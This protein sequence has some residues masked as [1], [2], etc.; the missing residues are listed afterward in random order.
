MGRLKT[1]LLMLAGCI[2]GLC[3]ANE[4]GAPAPT[5]AQEKP[6]SFRLDVMPVFFR[7][8]CNS[9]G[10]HG[11]ARGKDGFRL[12]LFG[13]DPA[14]DY[15]RLTQQMAG[16]RINLSVPEESLLLLKVTGKVPHTGGELFKADSERYAVLKKW[17]EQG[18]PDDSEN[19]PAPTGIKLLP[20]KWVVE[21]AG[22]K[23]QTQVLATYSDGSTRD[24][25]KLALFVTNNKNVV[26]INE[27]G[28]IASGKNGAAYFFARFNKFTIGSEAIVLPSGG[29]FKWPDDVKAVNYIDEAVHAKLKNL[30]ILPSGV[31][32]DEQFVRRIYLDLIGVVP[33][34]DEYRTFVASTEADKREKLIDTLLKRD[35]F[36]DLWAAKWSEWVKVIADGN[37]QN[38]A[39]R[40]AAVI[41]HDWIREQFKRNVP[42]DQFV[43]T[44]LTGNGSNFTSPPANFY[45]MI[46]PQNYEPK[47]VAQDI[48]QLFTG[49]RIQCAEC[50]NHPFD[51]WT[52][53]DY[54]GF[55]SF[56]TGV[57]RKPAAEPRE[58]YVYNDNNA[59]PMK[60]LLDGRPMPPKLLGGAAP[61]VKGKDARIAFADW[62]VSPENA[63][64]RNS[65][66]NRAWEQF[67]GRGIVE[68][69][70]D[71]RIS[72][73]PSNR[74]LLDAIGQKLA[75]YKFDLRKLIR[76]ICLSRTYQ[77]SPTVNASNKSDDRQFS[78]AQLRRLRADVLLDSLSQATETV[79]RYN[80]AP[81]GVRAT[82]LFEGGRRA[83]DYFLKTFGLSSRETVCAC[84]TR[85]EPTF[86]QSLHLIN[87]RTIQSKIEESKVIEKLLKENK[88]SEQVVDE[89]YARS[90]SRKPGADENEKLLKLIGSQAGDKKA[91]EDV[92][93]ALLNSTEFMFN[94]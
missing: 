14:G 18:A 50:H 45:T 75:D 39:D 53:D 59:Q 71:F 61:D 2:I 68:P 26:D 81:R 3:A 82:Q 65:M 88:N 44:Q 90:L 63:L 47:A 70:D 55:V 48:S 32:S 56:F 31:C 91:F 33:T 89:L 54:Y 69:V 34:P 29:D 49:I 22:K 27:S 12:S 57:R 92:F 76:D 84:E 83:G 62:L 35:E 24:V 10:C 73:P 94:H 11:S 80:G 79:T 15:F 16:R 93:W 85:T 9:G 74:E 6:V 41:Y 86:A 87:G 40:K 36:A 4:E 51:R 17:I 28:E 19:V 66:A 25:T 77:L 38:G 67:F 21:G 8:G 64:F 43:R 13:Y 72:N 37:G 58:Y 46:P 52:Q 23:Q 5:A 30:R 1:N 42:L 78:H 60:H 20:E 7:S